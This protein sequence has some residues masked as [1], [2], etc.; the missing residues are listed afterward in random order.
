M[1]QHGEEA[2]EPGGQ[3]RQ[4]R[5]QGQ[6]RRWQRAVAAAPPAIGER[7][8]RARRASAGSIGESG[9]RGEPRAGEDDAGHQGQPLVGSPV[10]QG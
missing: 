8:L 4:Q 3:A 6:A 1:Q 5:L 9:G 2:G 7:Q 10:L